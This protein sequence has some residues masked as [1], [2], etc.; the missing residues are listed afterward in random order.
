MKTLAYSLFFYYI[1]EFNY[2]KGFKYIYEKVLPEP[3]WTDKQ[4]F[5]E[6]MIKTINVLIILMVL[7]VKLMINV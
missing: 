3:K 6:E 2:L 5:L 7:S 1:H 4:D